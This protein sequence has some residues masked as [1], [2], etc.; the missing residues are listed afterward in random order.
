[1]QSDQ[2]A[3]LHYKLAVSILKLKLGYKVK[4]LTG[5]EELQSYEPAKS[6][7]IPQRKQK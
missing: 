4:I 7:L 1:M 6:P 5:D 3:T 2:T